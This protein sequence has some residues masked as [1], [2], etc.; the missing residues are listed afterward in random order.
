MMILPDILEKS[1]EDKVMQSIFE[2]LL[3]IKN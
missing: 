2:E 3:L 1:K